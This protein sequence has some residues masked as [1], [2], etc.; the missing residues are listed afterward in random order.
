MTL[1]PLP[2]ITALARSGALDRA[3][4]LFE[5]GGYLAAADNAA[6]LAVKGRLLKGR[7]LKAQ[8]AARRDLFAQSA[9]A[10]A[11]ADV[12]TPAPYLLINVATLA[13]LSGDKARGA[14]LARAVLSRLDDGG[15]I[16]ETPYWLSATRAEAL[17][18]MGETAR[19]DAALGA[20]I[21]L[22]PDSWADHASTLKQFRLI[23]AESGA[24]A[25][26]LTAHRPPLSAHF[27]G[28][29][30]VSGNDAATLHAQVEA[31]IRD[32]RIGFAYG[33]LAAGADIVIAEAALVAGAELH[34]IL[35]VR[36]EFYL[37]QSVTPFAGD[38]LARFEACIEAATSLTEISQIDGAFEPLTIALAGDVAMGSTVLN[39]RMLET[40]ACQIIVADDGDGIYGNGLHTARDAARWASRGHQQFVLKYPRSAGVDA[41]G[42]GPV[43]QPSPTRR[44][45]AV[46][47]CLITGTE[48]LSEAD[49]PLLEHHVTA[50]LRA[51]ISGLKTQP[52]FHQSFNA[53]HTLAFDLVESA[54]DAALL[55]RD[56]FA[57]IDLASVGLPTMLALTIGGH[58]DILHTSQ[59]ADGEVINLFGQR[60]AM[61]DEIAKRAHPG[62]LCVTENFATALAFL[63][64]PDVRA[65]WVGD[66]LSPDSENTLR[67]FA[68]I[69]G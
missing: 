17:L 69:K 46:L 25:E 26:W 67:L 13:F 16:A 20:A 44:I 19:A 47:Q 7:G 22:A 8:G 41:S 31:L 63:T 11:A 9:A 45:S 12:L 38:W 35:P 39:A 24:S 59:R 62:S 32:H 43:E 57:T 64:G 6:A 3:W 21:A 58:Y 10:Y 28:H 51:A 56:V 52:L 1:T 66:H 15:A 14:D 53:G 5:E 48:T 2:L 42:S 65:E 23:L 61:A 54:L 33:A 29:L 49:W 34:V 18:L 50:P 4:A 30:G 40:A 55:M 68:V 27:A 36:R 37:A 60:V